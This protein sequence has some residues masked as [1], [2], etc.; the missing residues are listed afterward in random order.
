MEVSSRLNHHLKVL[1]NQLLPQIT[2]T[3]LF[4]LFFRCDSFFYLFY[5]F[6]LSFSLVSASFWCFF[7][8]FLFYSVFSIFFCFFHIFLFFSV[9]SAFFSR[10]DQ[11][12]IRYSFKT[13]S[14]QKKRKKNQIIIQK[15][16][17]NLG[18]KFDKLDDS[19][20]EL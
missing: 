16:S 17:L 14:E 1:D 9:L 2:A 6:S 7:W 8:L 20:N 5:G 12:F 18:Q 11:H 4:A 15:H 10:F 19:M 3:M 13:H